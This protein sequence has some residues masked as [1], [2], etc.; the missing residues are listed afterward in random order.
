MPIAL[1]YVKPNPSKPLK[2]T[3]YKNINKAIKARKNNDRKRHQRGK[4]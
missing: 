1:E 4:R 2:Q 3:N